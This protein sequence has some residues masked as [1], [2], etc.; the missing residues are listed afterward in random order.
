MLYPTEAMMKVTVRV[1][2]GPHDGHHARLLAVIDEAREALT[3]LARLACAPS[4]ERGEMPGGVPVLAGL[5]AAGRAVG[6]S[7]RGPVAGVAR[8]CIPFSPCTRRARLPH[9]RRAALALRGRR[10]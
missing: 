2:V 6:R 4:E 10:C 7:V 3:A 5:G 8:T 1:D 9:T